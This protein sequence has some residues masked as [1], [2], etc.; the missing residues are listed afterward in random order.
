MLSSQLYR[1]AGLA[2]LM[3]VNVASPAPQRSTFAASPA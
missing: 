1:E 3:R 2:G